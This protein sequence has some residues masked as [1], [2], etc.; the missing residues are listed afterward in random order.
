[1]HCDGNICTRFYSMNSLLWVKSSVLYLWDVD[2]QWLLWWNSS[3]VD[4]HNCT[5]S[6]DKCLPLWV[7]LTLNG[8]LLPVYT[9]A[10]LHSYIS[11]TGCS[12]DLWTVYHA[13]TPPI[14]LQAIE[15]INPLWFGDAVWSQISGSTLAQVMACC[16]MA[17]IHYLNQCWQCDPVTLIWGQ[18][19]TGTPAINH[20][21]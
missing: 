7:C 19:H 13:G 12:G 8:L 18:F 6:H 17:P 21:N 1:M 2:L 3:I 11:L 10:S 16:M 20:K 9:F 4:N 15:S 5:V 14:P